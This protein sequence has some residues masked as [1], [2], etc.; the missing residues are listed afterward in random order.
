VLPGGHLTT[1]AFARSFRLP[2]LQATIKEALLESSQ[3][4]GRAA[5]SRVGWLGNQ[6]AKSFVQD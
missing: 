2:G 3:S 1:T 5:W 6:V 4:A